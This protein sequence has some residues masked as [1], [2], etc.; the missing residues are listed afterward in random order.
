MGTRAS[1]FR[2][3]LVALP[4]ILVYDAALKKIFSHRLMIELLIRRHVPEFADRIDFRSLETLNTEL[5]TLTSRDSAV[6]GKRGTK[7][8]RHG[9]CVGKSLADSVPKPPG[10]CPGCWPAVRTRA[11]R[12]AL[13]TRS[14]TATP[15]KSSWRACGK[16]D[17]LEVNGRD[18]LPLAGGGM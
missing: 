4:R 3:A 16:V 11:S 17:A 6:G 14:S 13:R 9:F 5:R 12:P 2:T 7:R 15:L 18:I 1:A 8:G 10:S